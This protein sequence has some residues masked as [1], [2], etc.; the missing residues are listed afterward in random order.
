MLNILIVGRNAL[1]MIGLEALFRTKGLRISAILDANIEMPENAFTKL[2]PHVVVIDYDSCASHI[3]NITDIYKKYFTAAKFMW[4]TDDMRDSVRYE[5]IRCKAD[6]CVNKKDIDEVVRA[7]KT[8]SDGDFYFSRD[9]L[10]RFAKDACLLNPYFGHKLALLSERERQV[11]S[12]VRE[13]TTNA[14]IAELLA[15]S[16]ETVKV[17]LRRIRQILNLSQ[18]KRPSSAPSICEPSALVVEPMSGNE[19]DN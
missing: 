6:G 18:K 12:L 17:H 16:P 3:E 1:E 15:I 11:L 7:V 8:V 10:M 4:I 19:P 2:D 9:L 5:A 14:E 13:G